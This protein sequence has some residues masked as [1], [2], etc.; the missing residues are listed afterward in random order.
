KYLGGVQPQ[1]VWLVVAVCLL[2]ALGLALGLAS[3]LN[4]FLA[5]QSYMAL[6]G[7]NPAAGGAYDWLLT[8]ALLLLVLRRCG[9][10]LS[11]GYRV[12]TGRWV[13]D[14]PVPAWPRYLVVYQMVLVYWSTGMHKVSGAW[15]PAGGFSALY[16]ILQEPTWRRWNMSWLAWV[17]PATQAATALT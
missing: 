6:T 5:L 3:R 15:T 11:L 14:E 16:Y 1:N 2:S 10:T 17:Y 13:S 12:R 7:L 9:Q 4:A 8:N